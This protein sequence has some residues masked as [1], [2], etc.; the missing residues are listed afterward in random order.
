MITP[1]WRVCSRKLLGMH[2]CTRSYLLHNLMNTQPIDDILMNRILGFFIHGLNHKDNFI[3]GFFE[4]TL[5]CNSSYMLVNINSILK[6][7][8]IKYMDL[9]S[10]DKSNVK[11]IIRNSIPEPDWRCNIIKELLSL[12][13]NQIVCNLDQT[14]INEMLLYISTYR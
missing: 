13:E 6:R 5:T 1:S 7:Y 4:N 10:M 11:K 14:E 3:S 8:N 12:R 9:F 2:Q